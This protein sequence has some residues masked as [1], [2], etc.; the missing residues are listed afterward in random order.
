MENLYWFV[1]KQDEVALQTRPESTASRSS[2]KKV[3]SCTIKC[4][5][6]QTESVF[7]LIALHWYVLNICWAGE[8]A[9]A[10]A[11]T[12]WFLLFIL[13]KCTGR[14]FDAR[15]CCRGSFVC[16]ALPWIPVCEP[17]IDECFNILHIRRMNTFSQ[18]TVFHFIQLCDTFL[19]SLG[20]VFVKLTPCIVVV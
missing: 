10:H 14:C 13:I 7:V 12:I 19:C 11:R 6:H 3:D 4:V 17:R 20:V 9:A 2:V 15:V 8:R 16:S 18:L 1:Y 5:F